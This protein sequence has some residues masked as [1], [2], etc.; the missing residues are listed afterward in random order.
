MIAGN[1]GDDWMEGRGGTD[2]QQGDNANT[3]QNDPA[4]GDDVMIDQTGN[5]DYDA[6][7]G[8]DIMV[9]TAGANRNH[10]MLGF[11]WVT[12]ARSPLAADDD[13]TLIGDTPLPG[14]PFADRFDLV[15]GLSGWD[16]D[17]LLRGDNRS[18][19]VAGEPE[20]AGELAFAGHELTDVAKIAGLDQVLG[21]GVTQF[22]GGNILLG[23][24]GSDLIQGRG[25][26]DVIDGDAWLNVKLEVGGQSYT[27]LTQ[28][29]TAIFAGTVNPRDITIVREVINSAEPASGL[30]TAEFSG[31]FLEYTITPGLSRSQMVISHAAGTQADGTDTVRNVEF[32]K[33]AD[34][35]IPVF[36]VGENQPPTG[37]VTI[38]DTTPTENQVLT[39]TENVADADGIPGAKTLIW[40]FESVPGTW[41]QFASGARFR[42]AQRPG[43]RQADPRGGQLHRRRGQA[44]NPGLAAD[45][46]RDERQRRTHRCG[47]GDPSVGHRG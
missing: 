3:L 17:D 40:Q 11:D 13:M 31:N 15:E 45:G 1:L 23:G 24:L 32:L 37:T 42:A 14:K 8:D 26:D 5:D 7:G 19:P 16:K 6:E 38:S 39:A 47:A 44:R 2:L 28:L 9:S 12:N 21:A 22:G 20:V 36:G 10:G 46:E 35:T 4:G 29:Q 25:G 27:S 41:T 30:D 33:F 34:Q 43:G 18:N